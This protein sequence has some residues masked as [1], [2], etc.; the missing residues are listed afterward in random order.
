MKV[1]PKTEQQAQE[2]KNGPLFPDGEYAFDILTAEEKTSKAGNEMLVLTLKV[3]GPEGKTKLVNDYLMDG[4]MAFK[5]RHCAVATGNEEHY[6]AGNLEPAQFIHKTGH[7]VLKTR[8]AKGDYA[9]QNVIADYVVS[10]NGNHD[11]E[12]DP[13]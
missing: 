5:L 10:G 2:E 1:T 6:T 3:F 13:F 11:G 12:P 9:A 7:V 4:T 8:A